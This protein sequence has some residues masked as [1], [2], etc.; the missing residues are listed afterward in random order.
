[1]KPTKKKLPKLSSV[2][3]EETAKSSNSNPDEK[4]VRRAVREVL[5]KNPGASDDKLITEVLGFLVGIGAVVLGLFGAVLAGAAKTLF[6]DGIGSANSRVTDWAR[7]N[8]IKESDIMGADG[9]VDVTK[10]KGPKALEAAG[11]AI[12]AV[13]DELGDVSALKS[14]DDVDPFPPKDEKEESAEK[15]QEEMKTVSE[16]AGTAAGKLVGAYKA[17][18][19]ISQDAGHKSAADQLESLKP[20]CA[21]DIWHIGYGGALGIAKAVNGLK[22]KGVKTMEGLDFSKIQDI[23]DWGSGYMSKIP[24]AKDPAANASS[25]P[26]TYSDPELA[27][28]ALEVTKGSIKPEEI[29]SW[30]GTVAHYLPSVWANL[31]ETELSEEERKELE[32]KSDAGMDEIQNYIDSMADA[33]KLSV[34]RDVG[35]DILDD[36]LSPD[37]YGNMSKELKNQLDFMGNDKQIK[38]FFDP[39]YGDGWKNRIW[40]FAFVLENE[41][42]RRV[43]GDVILPEAGVPFEIN[44]GVGSSMVYPS[45]AAPD[46]GKMTGHEFSLEAGMNSLKPVIAGCMWLALQQGDSGKHLAGKLGLVGNGKNV[47]P[48]QAY[49]IFK[50]T[51]LDTKFTKGKHG[52]GQK[53]DPQKF[54][55]E[56]WEKHMSDIKPDKSAFVSKILPPLM[57]Q[58][59]SSNLIPNQALWNFILAG[60]ESSLQDYGPG[61]SMELANLVVESQVARWAKLAGIKL[62]S[63]F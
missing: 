53:K 8:G 6:S 62:S 61:D 31:L 20:V 48:S 5:S 45:Q 15:Y 23:V 51:P 1:M 39:R 29:Q 25:M 9:E 4:H 19:A 33:T 55:S 35:S 37:D 40:G 22:E 54:W 49:G 21:A 46:G 63:S 11:I 3:F 41:D 30:D 16:T 2:L 14:I 57:Q 50:D 59:A 26:S 43:M 13:L 56:Q 58:I 27:E 34:I 7:E 17:I 10:L 32:K 44:L 18:A 38:Y 36:L 47:P 12:K 24:D 28:A 42:L 60:Q 52:Q